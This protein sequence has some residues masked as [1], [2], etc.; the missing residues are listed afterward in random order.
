MKK[1]RYLLLI[2][3]GL[4]LSAMS[5][6]TLKKSKMTPIKQDGFAVVEL[7]TSEG[8]SSCPSADKAIADLSALYPKDVYV[9]SFHMDY[10]NYLG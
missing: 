7:F 3:S 9:L 10:W 4:T 5:L 2:V 6:T 8:C 1:S